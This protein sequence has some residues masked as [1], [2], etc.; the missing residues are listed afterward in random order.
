[1]KTAKRFAW[2]LLRCLAVA[3]WFFGFATIANLTALMS[4]PIY[5]G[6]ILGYVAVSA[7]ILITILE[8]D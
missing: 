3:A 1:M 5:I 2:N 7:A 4:A 6:A 8:S